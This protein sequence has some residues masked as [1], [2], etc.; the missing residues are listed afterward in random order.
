MIS[1]FAVYFLFVIFPLLRSVL[2]CAACSRQ[3]SSD[4]TC[5]YLSFSNITSAIASPPITF[6]INVIC[7][8]RPTVYTVQRII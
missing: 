3:L 5:G 2:K 7:N 6:E 4:M 1:C 8:G